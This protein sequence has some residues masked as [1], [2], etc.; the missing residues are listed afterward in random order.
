MRVARA[1]P[2]VSAHVT[3]SHQ[4]IDWDT[5]TSDPGVLKL[6]ISFNARQSQLSQE[7]FDSNRD[8]RQLE[9]SRSGWWDV[10]TIVW[11]LE[12]MGTYFTP[13]ISIDAHYGTM[14]QIR[15]G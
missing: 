1:R 5:I 9:A 4:L 13:N 7:H 3:M 15:D 2:P 14:A 6:S 10:M 12:G 11:P 8:L